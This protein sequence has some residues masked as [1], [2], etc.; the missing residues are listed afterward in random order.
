MIVVAEDISILLI[1]YVIICKTIES[2][3][4]LR[5]IFLEETF[6]YGIASFMSEDLI[7]NMSILRR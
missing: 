1:I 4:L 2:S 6:T 3:H 5:C 7:R